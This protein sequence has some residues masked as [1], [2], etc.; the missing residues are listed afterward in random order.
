MTIITSPKTSNGYK[1][2]GVRYTDGR[3]LNPIRDAEVD[4]ISSTITG[5]KD[6]LVYLS[7]NSGE[8]TL[9]GY[10]NETNRIAGWL[11]YCAERLDR[12]AEDAK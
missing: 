9:Q 6:E 1:G 7:E 2:F 3:N 8:L 5:I 10:A 12:L 11:Q 4:K